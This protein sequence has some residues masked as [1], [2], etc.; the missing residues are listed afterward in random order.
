MERSFANQAPNKE[1]HLIHPTQELPGSALSYTVVR[2]IRRQLQWLGNRPTHNRAAFEG[3]FALPAD[4][5]KEQRFAFNM[6]QYR[7]YVRSIAIVTA[8]RGGRFALFIQPTPFISKTLTEEERRVVGP[9]GYQE[10]YQNMTDNL[11]GLARERI[12]VFSLLDVFAGETGTIYSDPIHIA[13]DAHGE[14]RGNRL[15]ASA[16]ARAIAQAWEI[17]RR[18]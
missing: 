2:A 13:K 17:E 18:C 4:W 6:E 14:S 9:D 15:M 8:A 16:M 11:L 7:K 1:S 12:P 3:M 10:L 5:S